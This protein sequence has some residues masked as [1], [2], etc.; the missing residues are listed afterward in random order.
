MSAEENKAL[1]RRFFEEAWNKRNLAVVDE[2]LAPDYV[3]RDTAGAPYFASPGPEPMKGVIT[4]WLR[5]LP[6]LSVSI[7]D[8]MAVGDRVVT[9]F[10]WGG[11]HHGDY[12]GGPH[13][14]YKP[15]GK[16]VTVGLIYIS[17]IAG[18]KIVEEWFACD[19][20]ELRRQFGALPA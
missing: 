13:P 3:F 14:P 10:I 12:L 11:T 18:G 9:R 15:T 1:V 2:I 8:I 7:E 17:R 19:F 16:R 20:E 5:V 4:D 6:D